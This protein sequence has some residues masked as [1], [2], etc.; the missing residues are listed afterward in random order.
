[1]QLA[2]KKNQ[3]TSAQHKP[4][5]L[6]KHTS[7]HTPKHMSKRMSVA[8]FNQQTFIK[9]GV[10]AAKIRKIPQ[11]IIVD[12]CGAQYCRLILPFNTTV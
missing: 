11:S 6:R 12:K 7:K 5:H 10:D 3:N 9:A 8:Q 4:R 2:T 1:M